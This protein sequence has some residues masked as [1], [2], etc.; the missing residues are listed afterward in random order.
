DIFTKIQINTPEYLHQNISCPYT[1]KP[2]RTASD[3][4]KPDRYK[5]EIIWRPMI[6]GETY[7]CICFQQAATFRD[8]HVNHGR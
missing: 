7:Q 6:S 5:P 1:L 2:V 3:I 4:Q 8:S